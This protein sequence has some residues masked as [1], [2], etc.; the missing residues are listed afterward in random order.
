MKFEVEVSSGGRRDEVEVEVGTALSC[1]VTRGRLDFVLDGESRSADWSEVSTGIYSILLGGKS[2][3]VRTFCDGPDGRRTNGHFIISTGGV[4]FD[5]NIRDCRT[6]REKSPVEAGGATLE[7]RAPMPGR[8]VKVLISQGRQV[9]SGD[10]LVVIEAMK[11]QN[12][13]RAPRPG[14]VEKILVEEGNGVEAGA[15]LL[16]LV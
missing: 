1:D 11:M 9:E 4:E 6:R 12:E 5:V 10:G 7:I 8:I 13:I 14:R 3:E 2:H 16:L 15:S